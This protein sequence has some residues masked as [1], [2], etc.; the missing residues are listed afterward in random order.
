MV[1]LFKKI[2]FVGLVITVAVAIDAWQVLH[3]PLNI[4]QAEDYEFAMGAS[5]A[6]LA[7]DLRERGWLSRAYYF[8]AWVRLTGKAHQLKAGEYVIEPG[9]TP[10]MLL[11]QMLQGKVKLYTITLIE[12]RIFLDVMDRVHASPDIKHTLQAR[13]MAS[14]MAAIG[15]AGEHAEGMF[16]PDTYSF[17]RGMD[18]VKFLRRAYDA[19]QQK[20]THAWEE[21][22]A[23]LPF[24]TPYEALIMASIVEKETA[25][26][27]ERRQ[28]A[29]VFINRLRI[30]M[31]LQ[32]DPT[33]I[34]GIGVS[35][36]G[37]IRL[38]DLHEDTPYN[39]YT[40]KGLPPT[41]IAMPGNDAIDA[42]MHPDATPYLYFVARG[43]KSGSHVFS[44]NL[45]DHEAAVDKF[46]RKKKKK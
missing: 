22:D 36:D 25:K 12:G 45:Q 11:E 3:A 42:V 27:S 21:R 31:R 33:V 26:D 2:L 37:N 7:K 34:Y 35:Y 14:V 46:Q 4:S 28:I 8:S 29:G 43:D 18:D 44:T 23:D 6:S 10:L 19:M 24:A 40:R 30:G 15:H 1:R 41:P 32:T 5:T 9:T 17:P 20:L 39:T 38:K 13:D 16:F